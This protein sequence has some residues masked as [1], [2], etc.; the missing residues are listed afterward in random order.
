MIL[1]TLGFG[2]VVTSALYTLNRTQGRSKKAG[3]DIVDGTNQV[4]KG[5]KTIYKDSSQ[6][7]KEAQAWYKNRQ[8]T[9]TE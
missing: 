3:E 1:E 6:L 7:V 8:Q 4:W 9:T 2:A 5:I